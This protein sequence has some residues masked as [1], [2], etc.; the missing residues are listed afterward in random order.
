M[1][2]EATTS[3][4]LFLL[5]LA[6]LELKV[7]LKLR[8]AIASTLAPNSASPRPSL[9]LVAARVQESS[10][11]SGQSTLVRVMSVP[12]SSRVASDEPQLQKPSPN[13]ARFKSRDSASQTRAG[14]HE[15]KKKPE[16]QLSP[17][18]T[19]IDIRQ[20]DPHRD[21]QYPHEQ[22]LS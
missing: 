9:Q 1:K 21:E 16:M 3:C 2:H 13:R 22:V 15:K 10:S 20:S 14:P 4:Y 11:L 19:T 12:A 18:Q 5:H 7:H 8:L 17:A 6:L